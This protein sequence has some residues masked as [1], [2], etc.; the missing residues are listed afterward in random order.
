MSMLASPS[1]PTCVRATSRV[2]SARRASAC[3]ASSRE[4]PY[5]SAKRSTDRASSG[6]SASKRVMISL[7]L[8]SPSTSRRS[9]RPRLP[10]AMTAASAAVGGSSLRSSCTRWATS[11][12]RQRAE[13]HLAAPAADGGQQP[14][15]LRGDEDQ[16]GVRGRLLQRLEEGVLRLV[17]HPLRGDDEGHLAPGLQASQGDA[18]L[19]PADL[20]HADVPAGRAGEVRAPRQ[21]ARHAL[22]VRHQPRHVR[23]QP[24][25]H[26]CAAGAGATAHL[27]LLGADEG[28]GEPD[29]GQ[30]LAHALWPSEQVGVVYRPRRAVPPGAQSIARGCP[31]TEASVMVR[32]SPLACRAST[33][34]LTL[35]ERLGQSFRVLLPFLQSN[36]SL[37]IGAVLVGP[38]ASR[39]VPSARTRTSG[40]TCAVLSASSARS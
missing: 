25:R 2:H 34:C 28:L 36:L 8:A 11:I 32:V 13:V 18:L 9:A 21:P 20:L 4:P 14:V 19:Q 16:R 30:L 17:V 5:S 3:S 15:H 31:I 26:P 37:V 1:A 38:A 12:H 33:A 6:F 7:R 27:G 22:V 29:R 23:V 35:M 39:C 24:L 40:E 10:P